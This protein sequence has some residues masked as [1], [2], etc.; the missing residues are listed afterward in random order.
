MAI[1]NVTSDSF[2]D[3]GR[4]LRAEAAVAHG[5]ELAAAGADIIDVGGESTRPGAERIAVAEEQAR[6]LPVIRNLAEQGL[7]VS[8]DTM[9]ASTARLAVEAGALIVNDVSG[10]LAD[11]AMTEA[12]ISLDVPL[13]VSHWRGHSAIMNSKAVYGDV[14]A[15]VAAELEYRVAELIVRGVSP[16]RLL[17]DPG[18]G[19]AKLSEHNWKVL[20]HLD[21]LTAFG[22]PVVVGASRKGFIGELVEEGAPMQARDFPSAVVAALAAQQGAWAV[23]VHDVETTKAALGVAEAWKRGA[24]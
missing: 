11:E 16:A 4:W 2:S 10:G 3:G 5:L 24:A 14:V 19:F 12:V 6:V 1:L 17:V 8:V 9:N 15:E 13:I 21:R 18:L 22:L 23:R 20:G 7:A